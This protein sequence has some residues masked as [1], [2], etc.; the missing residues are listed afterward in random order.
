M[1]IEN[2]SKLKIW[3]NCLCFIDKICDKVV[4][5]QGV[6]K[7]RESKKDKGRYE[8]KRSVLKGCKGGNEGMMEYMEK[9]WK[10][11]I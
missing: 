2:L 9:G 3:A 8:W 6:M 1:R 4:R 10:K 7:Q 11:V 5:I